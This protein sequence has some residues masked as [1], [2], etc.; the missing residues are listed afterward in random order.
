MLLVLSAVML[1]V[2]GARILLPDPAGHADRCSDR[3]ERTSLIVGLAFGVGLLTGLLA[4]GGGFL[5]VPVFIL[6]LGLSTAAAAGTSLV[7][8]A[9]LSVP[10]LL[11]HWSLGHIDWRIALLF[12]LGS[13]PGTQVGL[14]LGRRLD[15]VVARRAF[16]VLLVVFATAF[17]LR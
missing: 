8:A 12:G 4:N 11:V 3:R 9:A 10:T 17:L 1:L 13:V 15:G 7:V 16:G 5:L 2:V 14:W 6:L